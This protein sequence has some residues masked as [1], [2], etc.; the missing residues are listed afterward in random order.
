M[1]PFVDG[2]F[3][4]VSS[5]LVSPKVLVVSSVELFSPIFVVVS[6]SLSTLVPFVVSLPF[7]FVVCLLVSSFVSSSVISVLSH[8]VQVHFVKPIRETRIAAP[9]ITIATIFFFFFSVEFVSV[10][11]I[12]LSLYEFCL[13]NPNFLFIK[14]PLSKMNSDILYIF[15]YLCQINIKPKRMPTH[16]PSHCCDFSF[17]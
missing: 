17:Q 6:S 1:L 3:T 7:G 10:T 4:V 2:L 12:T 11:S 16:F 8:P 13:S 15:F 9:P 14:T 5:S